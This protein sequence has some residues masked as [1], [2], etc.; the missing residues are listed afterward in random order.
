[1][2]KSAKKDK[3]NM[4][5][6][7]IP[8]GKKNFGDVLGPYI[9]KNL[10]GREPMYTPL[11]HKGVNKSFILTYLRAIYNRKLSLR[12]MYY[13][14]QFL[15]SKKQNLLITIGSVI[16]WYTNPD[17]DIWGSGIMSR[18]SKVTN[19]NFYAVRG[20]YSQLRLGELGY[21]V[22]EYIGDPALLTPLIY[23]PRSEKKYTL[24]IIPHYLHYDETIKK[25][26]SD[27]IL[28]I[29]LLDAIEKVIEDVNSCEI[30]ISSSLHGI[31]IGHAYGIPSLWV[32]LSNGNIGGDDI[33]FADYFS[34][35]ELIEYECFEI[36]HTSYD[37]NYL[38]N[39]ALLFN[40]NKQLTLVKPQLLK[41]IQL[42]LIKSA[43][44]S[45]LPKYKELN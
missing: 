27:N 45:I 19:A 29:N 1:M 16:D 5:W 4:F 26:N 32:R 44:F 30:I 18:N 23:T 25:L 9:V 11:L 36:A 31:I 42:D 41:K 14:I 24:G 33:K 38:S 34:S 43:P 15:T 3:I 39:V 17:C 40:E 37:E 10:T 22:P 7:K 8:F 35:V 2:I 20:K 6:H 21:K 12:E 28:I 13:N